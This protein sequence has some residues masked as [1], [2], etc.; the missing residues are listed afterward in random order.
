MTINISKFISLFIMCI[1][2]IS[3]ISCNN[4]EPE[5]QDLVNKLQGTWTFKSMKLAAL[6]QTFELGLDD[7]KQSGGYSDF[8]D[9][10]LS[11]SGM[12]V[13]GSEYYVDGNKVL[14]P[15]YTDDDWWAKVSFSGS[16]MTMYY[17]VYS[18]G[19]KM[20]LWITYSRSNESRNTVET[21][22]DYL[23]IPTILE[24]LKI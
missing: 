24:I 22:S 3:L 21:T 2:S 12:S 20:E 15:W 19:V 11:F 18:E 17:N 10:V 9:D 4:D 14:L 1:F 7:L 16:E 6:G 8:Y 5:D 23:L 13:N